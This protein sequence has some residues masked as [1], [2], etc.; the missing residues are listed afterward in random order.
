MT[1]ILMT[2]AEA[3]RVRY[4][5]PGKSGLDPVERTDG[6]FILGTECLRD[7]RHGAFLATLPTFDGPD[8]AKW[9]TLASAQ[10]V[11]TKTSSR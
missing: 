3:E 11:N 5:D 8:G 9:R 10:A 6:S 7:P 1:N 4:N 2:K